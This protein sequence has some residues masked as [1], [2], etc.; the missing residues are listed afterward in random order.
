MPQY[1]IGDKMRLNTTEITV[2]KLPEVWVI[3]KMDINPPIVT[4]VLRVQLQG[5][6]T[7]HCM[8][9]ELYGCLTDDHEQQDEGNP[10]R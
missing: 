2:P 5:T 6:V 9:M 1:T 7:N 4:R 8:R 10:T 3:R